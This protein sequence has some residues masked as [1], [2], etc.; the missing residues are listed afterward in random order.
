LVAPIH[1]LDDDPRHVGFRGKQ[2]EKAGREAAP[3]E[4][5]ERRIK[6][7]PDIRSPTPPLPRRRGASVDKHTCKLKGQERSAAWNKSG[8]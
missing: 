6:E 1:L 5:S 8:E 3:V 4:Q 2:R 7:Y